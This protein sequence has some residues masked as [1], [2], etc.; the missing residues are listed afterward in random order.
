VRRDLA[1][2]QRHRLL[3]A[4]LAEVV[5]A[6]PGPWPGAS[7]RALQ[8]GKREVRLAVA[9]VGGAEQREQRGVLRERQEL[10]VAE[11][12]ALRREVERE[13]ADLGDEWIIS[14]VF[15]LGRARED[16]EQRDDEVDA[17]V[18]LEVRVRLAAADR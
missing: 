13:D 2:E 12:P 8:V 15:L 4:G 16:P 6:Q 5:Q 7:A 10:A 1:L 14:M 18:R 3:A 11:R 9:A 17:Q